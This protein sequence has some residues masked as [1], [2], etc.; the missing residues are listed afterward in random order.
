VSF[1]P[2]GVG[3]SRPAV[4]CQ[5]DAEQE[6]ELGD[7]IV[8]PEELDPAALRA[9]ADLFAQRCRARNPGILPYLSTANVARD[10]DLLR[11]AVGDKRLSYLGYSYGTAIGATYA[12]LFPGRARVLAL[13]G[14]LDVD[15][16]LNRRSRGGSARPVLSRR[17]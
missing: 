1:D 3:A 13:D 7:P 5:T 14:A 16:F 4:D 12:T 15:A 11:E 9:S 2:R 10:L 6:A 8:P 17:P